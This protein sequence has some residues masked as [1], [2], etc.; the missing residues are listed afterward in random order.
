MKHSGI[1]KPNQTDCN[2]KDWNSKLTDDWIQ[3]A[4]NLQMSHCQNLGANE[5]G[6]R[7]TKD[8][9]GKIDEMVLMHAFGAVRRFLIELFA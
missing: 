2:L 9:F 4:R 6:S 7:F 3:T 1:E 8:L 5:K